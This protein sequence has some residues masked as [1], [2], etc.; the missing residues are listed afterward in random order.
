MPHIGDA[1]ARRDGCRCPEALTS[2]SAARSRLWDSISLTATGTPC[3]APGGVSC[4]FRF[5]ARGTGVSSTDVG[6]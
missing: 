6:C 5:S 3:S 4:R 2:L 1:G